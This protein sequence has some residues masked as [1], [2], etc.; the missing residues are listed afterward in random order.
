METLVWAVNLVAVTFLC[1]WASKQ[2]DAGHTVDTRTPE[3]T[4]N[5]VSGKRED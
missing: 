4:S 3:N 2:D 1:F 5:A